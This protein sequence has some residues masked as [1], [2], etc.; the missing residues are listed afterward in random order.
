MWSTTTTGIDALVS[1]N[2]IPTYAVLPRFWKFSHSSEARLAARKK[3]NLIYKR[4]ST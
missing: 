3:R 1:F 4:I 2:R